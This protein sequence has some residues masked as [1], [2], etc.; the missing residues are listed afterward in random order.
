MRKRSTTDILLR[1]IA[2][3]GSLVEA[4]QWPGTIERRRVNHCLTSASG[5]KV[6]VRNPIGELVPSAQIK[7]NNDAD[8]AQCDRLLWSRG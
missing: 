8:A 2:A 7:V 4:A 1:D 6:V 3:D 5:P